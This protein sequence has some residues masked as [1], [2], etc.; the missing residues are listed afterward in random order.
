MGNEL[1]FAADLYRGAAGYYDSYRRHYPDAMIEY[2]VGQAMVDGQGRLLDLACGTGQ[3][4][5]ATLFSKGLVLGR[6]VSCPVYSTSPATLCRPC[7]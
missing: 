1:Q 4:A 6:R 2:V 5:R 7:C 3:P